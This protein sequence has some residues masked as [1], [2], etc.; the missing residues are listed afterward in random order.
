MIKP[1]NQLAIF[2]YHNLDCY[3]ENTKLRWE[4]NIIIYKNEGVLTTC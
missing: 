2:C 4:W 1:H 3:R